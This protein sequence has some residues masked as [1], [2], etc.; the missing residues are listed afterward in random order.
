MNAESSSSKKNYI[1]PKGLRA[2][3]TEL[4]DLKY[5]L[6]PEVTQTVA[7]AASNGD[8]S[9]NGDYIYG[10]KKLREIDG[11][12]HFLSKRIDAV[13][14]IDPA[15]VESDCAV[16]GATVTFRDEDDVVKTYS[17][18]GVDE[19]DVNEGKISWVSPLGAALLKAKAQVG[20]FVTF[21]SPKG[22]QDIEIVEILFE[23]SF[24]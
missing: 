1:T 3:Q 15:S 4:Q 8:R 5:T 19:A 23:D 13:E 11:R 18:V 14:V 7:W 2:L 20:D 10:K 22:E 12:I 9:E 21:N 6:R 17:I 24:S 16:F